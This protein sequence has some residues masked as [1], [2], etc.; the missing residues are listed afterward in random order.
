[1]HP[2]TGR[3]SELAWRGYRLQL[4]C[5]WLLRQWIFA[6]AMFVKEGKPMP[7]LQEEKG[8]VGDHVEP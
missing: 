4:C 7:W 3:A 1:M 8:A 6:N 2:S 5:G